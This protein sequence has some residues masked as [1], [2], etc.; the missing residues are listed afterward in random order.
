MPTD[1]TAMSAIVGGMATLSEGGHVFLRGVCWGRLPNPDID[2]NHTS[3][4]TGVGVFSSTLEGLTPGTIYYVRAYVVTDFG[5]AYGDDQSFITLESG[6]Y[7]YVDLGLPSGNLWATCN[8]GADAPEDYG[9]YFAWAETQPKDDYSWSNYQ[10]CMGNSNTLTKYCD[11]ANHGYNGY[12]DTLTIL[13]PEDDAATTNWG[14]D[15][16]MPTQAEFQELLDNTT[17]TIIW[18]NGVRGILFTAS[19]GNSLFLPEAGYCDGSILYFAGNYGYYWSSSLKTGNLD[20]AWR[21]NFDSGGYGMNGSNRCGGRSVRPVRLPQS[22]APTGA[23][24]GKFTI[25]E[26]GGQVYFSQGNLQYIGTAS[27]PYWKF[28]DNQWECFGATG[29]NNNNQIADRDLFGWGTNGYDHG[30]VCY[31]PWSTSTSYSDYLA[32]GSYMNNLYD[33]TGQ[34]EWGYNAISNGGN[35]E[36]SGWRTLT[37]NEWVYVFIT[38]NT[39]S[40]IRYAFA[41]V[42]DVNG[43]ILLPDN[44][45]ATTYDLNNTNSSSANYTSNTITYA[46]WTNILEANGAVFLPAAGDRWKTSV[47]SVNYSGSY[48]SSSYS[49]SSGAYLM[50]FYNGYLA[51]GA[52]LDRHLGKSV[53]L[54]CG[55]E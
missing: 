5:L 34:A 15:W 6:D 42:N 3:E 54:V 37:R 7:A 21:L 9:D 23:I 50:Y 40:G 48:W 41:N 49:S 44:W 53:R 17:A 16:R 30:A 20:S 19:N 36:N 26:D 2:G 11:K 22:N 13:L 24:D 33:Q 12:T 10:Y 43:V 51:P 4:G 32:Y 25:N 1:I 55:V 39:E 38:R 47:S 52:S 45:T 35:T 29:Q 28:A 8:V 18:Q 46:D 14:G 27:T 31:Q